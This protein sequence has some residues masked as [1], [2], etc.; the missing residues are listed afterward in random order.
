VG[1]RIQAAGFVGGENPEFMAQRITRYADA[2]GL[3]AVAN[4][5]LQRT[6]D[7][8]MRRGEGSGFREGFRMPA[9]R[10]RSTR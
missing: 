6:S 9:R 4:G 8:L 3:V 10:E 5:G 1:A 2:A 7:S